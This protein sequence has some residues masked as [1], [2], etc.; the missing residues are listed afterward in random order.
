M[1]VVPRVIDSPMTV[2]DPYSVA[3]ISAGLAR[4]KFSAEEIARHFLA[5]NRDARSPAE[6]LHHG[7]AGPRDRGGT[8]RR[9]RPAPGRGEPPRGSADSH[10]RTS[11]AP[12]GVRTTC[13]SRMLADHVAAYDATVVERLRGGGMVTLGKTNLDEFAMGS[14][15]ESS[16]FG[17]VRNPWDPE[18]V[19]GGSSGGSAAAVAAGLA[20]IGSPLPDTGG[21]H[22]PA[23]RP[24]RPSPD[25]S[26]PTAE[27]RGTGSWPSPRAFDQGGLLAR[28]AEDIALVF[29]EMAGFDERDSTSLEVPVG[30]YHASLDAPIAGLRVGV[31][32]EH[33]GDGLDAG[34]RRAIEAAVPRD[35]SDSARPSGRSASNMR[36]SAFPPTTCWRRPSAPPTSRAS[37]GYA[38]AIARRA[39]RTWRIS[40]C[41]RAPRASGWRS[42]VASS[43]APM[44]LSKGVLRRLLRQ[45]PAAAPAHR[46]RLPARVRAGWTSSQGRRPPPPRSGSATASTTRFAMYLADVF[47]VG[48]EPGGTLRGVRAGGVRRRPLP[49]G[50]QL[51]GNHLEEARLLNVAHRFQQATEWH[52]AR[53]ALA[54]PP[55]HEPG[56]QAALRPEVPVMNGWQP[57]IGLEVHARLLTRS[58]LFSGAPASYGAAPN[59]Q[60]C[61][62]DLGL[63]G[64]LP[65]LNREAVRMA[66]RF[67]LAVGRPHLAPMRLRTQELL[68]PGPAQGVSDQ[69]VRGSDHPGRIDRHRARRQPRPED[70]THPRPSRR[71]RRPVGTR[72]TRRRDRHRPQPRGA[73][74]SSRS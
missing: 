24:V 56:P 53:P 39:P 50:L 16:H 31:P 23:R 33:F 3:G 5:P 72:R 71:G 9:R 59:T 70:R 49:V 30:D 65:V 41:D 69:P 54:E 10:T 35:S 2:S 28:T 40:S 61:A 63:P 60:A 52:L 8:P 32:E 4:G 6:F 57:V 66:V 13:G 12:R 58:K 17:P 44:R 73:P 7:D 36:I 42:S 22:P 18:R 68:L 43:L 74:R 19:A 67:G 21:L 47:T 46:G 25:S 29:G 20:P 38:T 48:V 14:S 27:S 55:R 45:G 26:R 37:T 15:T 64:V 62:V 11:S 51:T 1:Y 34:V